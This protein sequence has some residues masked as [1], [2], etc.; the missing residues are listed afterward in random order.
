MAVSGQATTVATA[1]LMSVVAVSPARAEGPD[2]TATRDGCRAA[3][4][5]GDQAAARPA[6][7]RAFLMGGTA[8]DMH[9]QVESLVVGPARPLMEE[10]VSASLLADAA[11][12]VAP[13]EPWGYLA[14]AEIARRLED[15]EMLDAAIA[16][17]RR[18]APEHEAT[19][20]AIALGEVRTSFW[21]WL[22]R[23]ALGLAF[24]GTIAHAAR[25]W[26]AA[27]G[28]ASR[29][30]VVSAASLLVFG[31]VGLASTAR[32]APAPAAPAESTPS[33]DLSTIPIDDAHPDANIPSVEKQMENPLA[34]G[35]LLQD[36]LARAEKASQR[37]DHAAAA[38]F[39]AAVAKGVP[40]RA[41]AFTKICE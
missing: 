12:R 8:E 26:R 6:C 1:L 41:Y 3:L 29:M 40:R 20:R 7:K 4:G 23:L 32:A 30:P 38:R 25:R 16:D 5:R 28:G 34:F 24:L 17:A 27:R 14:R 10:L 22:G 21:A 37:G 36:L 18:V 39:Y 31:L 19:K 11:L 2:L 33:S 15:R 35:Y 13:R 9:N